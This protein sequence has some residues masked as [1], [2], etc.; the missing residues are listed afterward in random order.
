MRDPPFLIDYGV[1]GGRKLGAGGLFC[2]SGGPSLAR[3][4]LRPWA[5]VTAKQPP[6][7]KLAHVL[8]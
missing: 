3:P 1:R 6:Y 8:I 2:R 7:S 4:A 5:L